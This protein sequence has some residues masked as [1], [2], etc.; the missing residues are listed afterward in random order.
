M[1]FLKT[2][3]L[4]LVVA[5]MASCYPEK[6]RTIED[7]D[8]IGSHLNPDA[9]LASLQ[10]FRVAD[11]IIMIYDTTEEA[12]EYPAEQAALILSTIR[13]NMLNA[14]WTEELVDTPDVYLSSR[15]WETTTVGAIFYPPY[16]NPWYPGYPG[17]PGYWPGWG[18]TSYYRYTTGTVTIDM[19]DLKTFDPVD[20]TYIT[21]AWNAAVNGLIGSTS[22]NS[23]RIES[24]INQAFIQSPYLKK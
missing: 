1:N 14:G 21:P 10:T 12:P 22:S 3:T 19:Y 23:R 8:I 4:L 16:W 17:Y 9:N 5:A 6:D 7:Y 15:I 18:G 13:T 24:S 20:D 11:S 2:L